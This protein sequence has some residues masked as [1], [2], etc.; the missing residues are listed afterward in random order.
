MNAWVFSLVAVTQILLALSAFHR[1]DM[2]EGFLSV[3]VG[4]ASVSYVIVL[5]TRERNG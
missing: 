1:R 5:V 2:P 3:A 4:V